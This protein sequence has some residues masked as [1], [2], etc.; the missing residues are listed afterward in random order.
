MRTSCSMG[1]GW[2]PALRRVGSRRSPAVLRKGTLRC[3]R[4]DAV[5]SPGRIPE[6]P[7]RAKVRDMRRRIVTVVVLVA[8][9]AGFSVS[10]GLAQ[11]APP[12]DWIF[13]TALL[14]AGLVIGWV[15]WSAFRL[16]RRQWKAAAALDRL[17]P[18][19]EARRA[20]VEERRRLTADIEASVRESLVTIARMAAALD[21]HVDPRSSL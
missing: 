4:S 7:L 12:I 8:L 17:D 10:L 16:G 3:L 1:A 21:E 19:D 14:S 18:H 6:V 13:L 20:V 15:S 9:A 11:Q 2:G 5:S